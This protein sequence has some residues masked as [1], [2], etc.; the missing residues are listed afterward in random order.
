MQVVFKDIRASR[1]DGAMLSAPASAR[2]EA[3]V[4]RVLN[5]TALCAWATVAEDGRAHINIGYY[6]YSSALH[7]YLLS[8]PNS[9]HSRN[10]VMNPSMAVAVFAS[11]Q[12]WTHPGRGVQLFGT[13]T[14][15][16]PADERTA[17][18]IYSQRFHAYA[19]WR[20]AL[21]PGDP[22]KAY[23]FYCFNAERIKVLD[24]VEF[25]DAVFIEGNILRQT[26]S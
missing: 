25:G 12:D 11:A 8:H 10:V 20:A 26:V 24:E 6:A 2:V 13:C 5:E 14:Q 3:C 21:K 4:E 18:R 9:L 7:L 15:V 22:A 16:A 1:A 19:D 17:A 23:R